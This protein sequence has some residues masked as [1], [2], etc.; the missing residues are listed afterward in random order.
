MRG[1]NSTDGVNYASY[2][3]V[4]TL[5]QLSDGIQGQYHLASDIL[6]NYMYVDDVLARAHTIPEGIK[7]CDEVRDA[8]SSAGFSLRKWTANSYEFPPV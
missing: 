3:A 4:R 1:L 6:R 7:A 5:H 2:L 8:L